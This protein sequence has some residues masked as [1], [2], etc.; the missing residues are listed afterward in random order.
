MRA[1][2]DVYNK[3]CNYKLIYLLDHLFIH[4]N[5]KNMEND[6]VFADTTAVVPDAGVPKPHRL[7]ASPLPQSVANRVALSVT[8]EQATR[9][10][11]FLHNVI[12]L[13]FSRK[14]CILLNDMIWCS[15]L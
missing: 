13:F 3:Y 4:T 10:A 12:F 7:P 11:S 15:G 8:G 9:I 6:E 5:L 14:R 1:F 2:P